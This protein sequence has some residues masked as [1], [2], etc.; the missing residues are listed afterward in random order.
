MPDSLAARQPTMRAM[1]A[2]SVMCATAADGIREV[3]AFGAPEQ[4]RFDWERSYT[5]DEWLDQL[6]TTGVH[7]QLPPAE[8]QEVLAGMGTAID[9]FGGS[10]PM[11]YTSV[12][13]TAVRTGSS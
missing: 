9:A 8:L 3:G 11:H 2:Y 1:D 4:W 7:T 12:V 13:A 5:R 10:F 6:P